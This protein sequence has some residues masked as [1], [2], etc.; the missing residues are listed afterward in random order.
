MMVGIISSPRTPLFRRYRRLFAAVCVYNGAAALETNGQT[1]EIPE[2]FCS[3]FGTYPNPLGLTESD[4]KS[5]HPVVK[6]PMIWQETPDGSKVRVPNVFV[7]DFSGPADPNKPAQLATEEMRMGRRKELETMNWFRRL[8]DK[9]RIKKRNSQH[10]VGRYDENRNIYTSDMFQDTENQVDGYSGART[11]HVGIDLGGPVGTKIYAFSD[12]TIHSSGYNPALGDYG[13]VLVIEH[14][15]PS[16]KTVWALYGHLDAKS[17]KGKEPGQKLKQGQVVAFMGDIHENGG[18]TAPHLHF[19]LSME[20]PETH[21]MPGAVSVEDR[22]KA[23]VHY[24]DPRWVLG[25]LY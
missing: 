11:I 23:L 24:P 22:A 14:E 17:T 25:P 18:W 3:P 8:L 15:L 21:D 9:R 6:F 4:R 10:S 2:A 1:Y 13:H 12:G 19:Q 5:F 20:A 7:Y 16:N